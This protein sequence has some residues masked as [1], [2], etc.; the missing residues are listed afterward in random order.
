MQSA[1]VFLVRYFL[2]NNVT[3]EFSIFFSL[4]VFE[5][6]TSGYERRNDY[7]KQKM[8]GGIGTGVFCISAGYMV[9]FFSKKQHE[10]DYSCIFYIMLVAMIGDIMVSATLKKVQKI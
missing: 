6:L 10:K 5:S 8:W 3:I 4:F 1:S 2:K 9:D 7:G